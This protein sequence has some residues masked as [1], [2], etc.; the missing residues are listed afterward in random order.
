MNQPHPL[1]PDD[2]SAADTATAADT[3]ATES[4]APWPRPLRIAMLGTRGAPARYGGFETAVDEIGRRL[5][6]KGHDV[7]VYCRN[8]NSGKRRDPDMYEGMRLVHLPAAR[9]R[10]LETLSHTFLSAAHAFTVPKYDAVL[11]CNAANALALPLLRMRGMPFAVH[12]DGLEWR[13]TKWGPVGRTYYRVAESLS[14]R[15]SDALIADARGIEQYYLDEF[16]ARTA[17]IAYGAPDGSGIGTDKLH[18]LGLTPDGF[19]VVVARFEPENHVDLM[20]EGYLRSNAKLPLVV[21][22]SVP[23]PTEHSQRISDLAAGNDTVHLVGGVWDQD[24]L[25]QLYAGALTY[26]HG[27]SVGGTNPSLLRAM[28]A[29]TA[30]IAYD[31]VFNREVAGPHARYASSP[32]EIAEAIDE[33]ESDVATTT[34]RGSLL[35]ARAQ[36]KYDWDAVA[37]RYEELF[38]S[39]AAGDSQRGLHTGRRA[40]RSPWRDGHTPALHLQP[41]SDVET[42]LGSRIDATRTRDEAVAGPREDA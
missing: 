14:V 19:H 40:R 16:G 26:L 13:R 9:K 11:V 29:G 15:W 24:L 30:T 18:E 42:A 28:G 17:G 38:A 5:V 39:L 3:T 27:H 41:E 1:H 35:A 31:I 22:G 10:A 7:T 32:G 33:A 36:E 37:E 25:D 12:V 21:V 2:I 4:G 8:G 6:A 34:H 20:I 23:Y